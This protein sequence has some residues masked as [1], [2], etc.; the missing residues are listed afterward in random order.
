MLKDQIADDLKAAMRARDDVRRRTL[1]SLRAA[2]LEAE[3]SEREEGEEA[4]LTE[5]QELTV[6]RKQAKQRREAID[7][8]EQ[9]GRT[10]LAEKERAELEVIET[11]LPQ[12][13]SDEEL[14]EMIQAIIEETGADSM[15][16]MG[17]VMGA[18]MQRLRGRA[19]GNRVRQHV[20]DLL[21][22]KAGG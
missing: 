3:I 21:S 18:A 15:R 5:Q 8:Y 2:L 13:L 14:R 6:L 4:L 17:K 16:D 1:R 22:G 11:Y 20:E 10:D 7:Q 9:A 12:P 19:D